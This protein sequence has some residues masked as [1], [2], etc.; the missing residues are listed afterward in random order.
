MQIKDTP[1]LIAGRV[2]QRNR[3]Q[4][5]IRPCRSRFGI[6]VG[7]PCAWDQTP[8]SDPHSV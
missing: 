6:N 3:L 1:P 4:A 7:R 5:G 8:A 2:F